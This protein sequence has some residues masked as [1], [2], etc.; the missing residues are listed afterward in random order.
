MPSLSYKPHTTLGLF[1]NNA[2]VGKEFSLI[3][4]KALLEV[5]HKFLRKLG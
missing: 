5:S 3:V 4:L 2:S 1:L